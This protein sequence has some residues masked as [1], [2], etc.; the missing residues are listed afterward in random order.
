MAQFTV[1]KEPATITVNVDILVFDAGATAGGV[2]FIK[3]Y[4]WGGRGLTSTG[5]RTRWGRPTTNAS[6]AFTATGGSQTNPLTVSVCR[7]GTFATPATMGADPAGN[8]DSQ[9]WNL[10]GGGGQ[11]ILPIGGEWMVVNSATAGHAQVAVQNTVGTDATA[12]SYG[13]Q[14]AE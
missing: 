2:G 9:D 14:W 11:I 1:S 10:L 5:Y 4:S 8:L 6:G 12:S 7:A 3:K 13:F